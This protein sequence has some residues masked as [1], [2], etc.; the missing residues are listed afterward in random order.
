VYVLISLQELQLRPFPFKVEIPKGEIDYD[1]QV[2]QVSVLQAE[3]VARL[4]S[5]SLGE[6]EIRGSL[7]VTV[8]APCD[9]C[10]ETATV[11]VNKDFDLLYCPADHVKGG[12]EDEIEGDATEIAFYEGDRLN[13]NDVLREVV[14]LALPMRLVCSEECKGICPSC[15]Q[16]RNLQQCN[17]QAEASDDRWSKLRALRTELAPRQ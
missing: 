8:E 3:G 7:A 16:N 15:G 6:I 13:L 2:K 11:P 17:C 1:S 14:L 9:R 10:L 12:G 4:L 5:H